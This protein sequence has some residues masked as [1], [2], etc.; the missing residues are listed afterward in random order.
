[1]PKAG[2]GGWQPPG[3][4]SSPQHRS[5]P[6]PCLGRRLLIHPRGG[7]RGNPA[8]RPQKR[9]VGAEMCSNRCSGAG[10][11]LPGVSSGPEPPSAS[12]RRGGRA[13]AGAGAGDAASLNGD[14]FARTERVDGSGAIPQRPGLVLAGGLSALHF[15][16]PARGRAQSGGAETGSRIKD[17]VRERGSTKRYLHLFCLCVFNKVK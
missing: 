11:R 9:L 14:I 5:L 3:R 6:V 15:L 17:Q 12:R 10:P 16:S 8:G 7:G 1:M 13:W 2:R 4:D